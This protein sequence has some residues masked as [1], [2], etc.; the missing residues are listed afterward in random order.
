MSI[1]WETQN[2]KGVNSF[3]TNIQAY[4]NSRLAFYKY[5]QGYL[6]TYMIWKGKRITNF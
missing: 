2:S 3:Q 5:G 1:D 6:R 4:C